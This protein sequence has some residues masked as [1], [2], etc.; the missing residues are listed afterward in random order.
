MTVTFDRTAS[1]RRAPSPPA[2][3]SLSPAG[4]V[5]GRLDGA[6]WPRSRALTR[7]LPSLAAA[8]DGLWGRITCV[9][10]NPA[11]WPVI[12]HRVWVAGRT[13][14]VGWVTDGQDAHELALLSATGVRRDLLVVPPETGA[15]A[16]ARLMAASDTADGDGV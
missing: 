6:W 4:P 5:P 15:V 1:S 10:V 13:V 8:L 7:E 9:T 11:H 3:L 12:P 14:Q 2:R 16:A